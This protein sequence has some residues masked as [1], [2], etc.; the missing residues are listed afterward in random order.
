[1]LKKN[2]SK[3]LPFGAFV[4][5]GCRLFAFIQPFDDDMS[6]YITYDRRNHGYDKVHSAAPPPVSDCSEG[7]SLTT[8]LLYHLFSTKAI[9]FKILWSGTFATPFFR[10]NSKKRQC[11]HIGIFCRAK[12]IIVSG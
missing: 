10:Q 12:Y 7:Q 9:P 6:Y 3:V 2:A 8:F 5:A 1:M 4:H 11:G